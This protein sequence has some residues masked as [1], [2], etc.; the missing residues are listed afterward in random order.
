VS[1]RRAEGVRFIG[2][3]AIRLKGHDELAPQDV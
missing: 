2:A 1:S 3:D